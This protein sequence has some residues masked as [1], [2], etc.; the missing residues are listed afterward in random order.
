R[1][2]ELEASTF[3]GSTT[4]S[5]R[6][7]QD[8]VERA[9]VRRVMSDPG[10]ELHTGTRISQLEQSADRVI[11]TTAEGRTFESRYVVAADGVDSSIRRA[12]GIAQSGRP[13]VSWWQSVY[14]HGDLDRWA[15]HRPCIQFVT[16]AHSGRHVQIA[17]VD[18]RQRWVTLIAVPPSEV[19]PPD[20]TA[21][22]ATLLIKHAVGD[23]A[24]DV[25]IRDIATFRVSALNADRYRDGRVF[26]A[27]D[28]AHVLPPTGG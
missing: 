8:L 28:A 15:A 12:C 19:R 9:L 13:T 2:G 21:E 18:G 23:A 4:G 20:L 14:W 22:Q 25:D 11:V 26:L 6:V 17:S 24:I 10:V 7:S 27:G 1:T 16:G 3:A 5:C